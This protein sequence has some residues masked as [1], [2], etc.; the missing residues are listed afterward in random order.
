MLAD[1]VDG[2]NVRMI[3]RSCR[4]RFLFET[5]KTVR[6]GR[7]VGGQNFYRNVSAQSRVSSAIDLAHATGAD[8]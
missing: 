1:V 3:Q 8:G 5:R 2:K 4:T 6:I 7:Q